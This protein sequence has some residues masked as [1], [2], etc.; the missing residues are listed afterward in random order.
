MALG[1]ARPG[2]GRQKGSTDMTPRH[3]MPIN[4]TYPHEESVN[5]T[6]LVIYNV[7]DGRE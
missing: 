6:L 7:L 5:R 4:D 1:G 3:V 2:A